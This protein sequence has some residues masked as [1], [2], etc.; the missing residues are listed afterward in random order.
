MEKNEASLWRIEFA[1]ELAEFYSPNE[2]VKMIVLGGSPT[3]GL[4]D[5]YSDLDMVV[6]WDPFDLPWLEAV[7]LRTVGADRKF[8]RKTHEEGVYLESYYFGPLKADFGHVSV[9]LWEKWT[10]AVLVHHELSPPVQKSIAGFLASE[11]LYGEDLIRTW[12]ARLA[13][14]P[15]ALAPKMVK[16]HLGFFQQGVLTHQALDRGDVLFFVD[17]LCQMLKKVLGILAGLNRVYFCPEEPRWVAQELDAMAIKP[18]DAWPRMREIL[19]GDPAKA[20]ALLDALLLEVMD[21]VEAHMPEIDLSR[22]R[23]GFH[24][25][26]EACPAKPELRKP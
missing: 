1:R 3:K 7:P 16:A 2:Q 18:K 13:E 26:V 8:F 11:P 9:A 15:E 20:P 10:D 21:L 17:G 22:L 23:R 5:A 4:S 6:Y 25:K 12:K 24:T 14:Y 19:E